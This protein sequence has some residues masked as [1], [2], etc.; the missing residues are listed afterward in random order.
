MDVPGVTRVFVERLF[1]GPGSV[2][3]FP[4][5]EDVYA[6]TGGIPMPGDIANIQAYL[7]NLQ[8]ATAQVYVQAPVGVPINIVFNKFAPNTTASQEAV[9]SELRQ[10]FRLYSSVSGND[11][12]VP[13]MPYLATPATWLEVW[14][15]AALV[16]AVGSPT[17]DIG[18]PPGD[19][20]LAATQIAVLG[21]VAFNPVTTA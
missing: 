20:V 2:R 17:A 6:A 15:A 12:V 8:P 13:A 14:T 11:K 10:T 16:N 7:A 19:V 4:L 18:A 1:A 9:M 5:M 3:I 21:S